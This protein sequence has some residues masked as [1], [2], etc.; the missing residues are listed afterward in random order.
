MLYWSV[1]SQ[2]IQA[3]HH[4]NESHFS[5]NVLIL[6]HSL[7]SK[8]FRAFWCVCFL[9]SHEI[10]ETKWMLD[11]PYILTFIT[12]CLGGFTFRNVSSKLIHGIEGSKYLADR[13]SSR[14]S[15]AWRCLGN[16]NQLK[17]EL[18]L[19]NELKSM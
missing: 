7:F 11:S 19:I 9:A 14:I 13:A 8:P 4:C 2:P 1:N 6:H 16:M 5:L 15:K 18:F 17:Y 10:S 12:P 3:S